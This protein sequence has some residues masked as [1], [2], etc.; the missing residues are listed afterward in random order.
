M[1][2]VPTD[3]VLNTLYKKFLR[4][5]RKK[6]QV[7]EQVTTNLNTV[8]LKFNNGVPEMGEVIYTDLHH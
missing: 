4:I 2:K 7:V 5:K 1:D 8:S 6:E 3:Y